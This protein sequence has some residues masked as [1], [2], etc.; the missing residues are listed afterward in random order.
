MSTFELFATLGVVADWAFLL[1]GMHPAK[2]PILLPVGAT[3]STLLDTLADWVNS[4]ESEASL[5]LGAS[6]LEF[7][8]SAKHSK[9]ETFSDRVFCFI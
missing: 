3:V 2:I 7:G 4:R 9:P 6:H 8:L 5:S 1:L